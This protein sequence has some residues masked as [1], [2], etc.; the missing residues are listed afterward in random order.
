MKEILKHGKNWK[1]RIGI[2]TC[3]KCECEFAFD[4]VEDVEYTSAADSFIDDDCDYVSSP[5]VTCPECGN[6]INDYI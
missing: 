4:H 1:V 2:L 6:H 3:P 5:Y